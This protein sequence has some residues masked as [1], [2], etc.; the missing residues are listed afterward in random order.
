MQPLHFS[1]RYVIVEMF[2]AVKLT[3][4]ELLNESFLN[5]FYFLNDFLNFSYGLRFAPNYIGHRINLVVEIHSLLSFTKPQTLQVS[6]SHAIIEKF[7]A[8]KMCLVT[9]VKLVTVEV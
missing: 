7:Q 2:Q 1:F 5:F 6:S 8:T 3:L 9:S 4:F